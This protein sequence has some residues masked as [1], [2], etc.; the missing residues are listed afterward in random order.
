MAPHQVPRR[1]RD[2]FLRLLR[3]SVAVYFRVE[4]RQRLC[5]L[6]RRS[7]QDQSIS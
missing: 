2:S 3:V 4:G 1:S 5:I 6:H 7:P